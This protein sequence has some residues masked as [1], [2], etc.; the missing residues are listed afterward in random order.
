MGSRLSRKK[1]HGGRKLDFPKIS[2]F[3]I[4]IEIHIES[5][6]HPV[7]QMYGPCEEARKKYSPFLFMLA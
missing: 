5:M 4:K 7:G 6:K 2:I 1:S 3:E